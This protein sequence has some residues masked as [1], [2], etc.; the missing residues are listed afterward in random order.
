MAFFSTNRLAI[1]PFCT[2]YPQAA[3]YVA[4]DFSAGTIVL[5]HFMTK[6]NNLLK[7]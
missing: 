5:L 3:A 1:M 4:V 7:N 6:V 2:F